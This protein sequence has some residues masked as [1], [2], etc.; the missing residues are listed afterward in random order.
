MLL[1]Q[2]KLVTFRFEET[3]TDFQ[4]FQRNHSLYKRSAEKKKTVVNIP[5]LRA[6]F[7]RLLIHQLLG[8]GEKFE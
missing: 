1:I 2:V 7:L 4:K 6:R 8:F 5:N 3:V